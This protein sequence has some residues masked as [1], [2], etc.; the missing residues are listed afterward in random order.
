MASGLLFWFNL[1]LTCLILNDPVTS[2]L[3]LTF[4]LSP[5]FPPLSHSYSF[6][7]GPAYHCGWS[8]LIPPSPSFISFI[9]LIH[10]IF[11]RSFTQFSDFHNFLTSVLPP[12]QARLV[13]VAGPAFYPPTPFYKNLFHFTGP[14]RSL[15]ILTL[16]LYLEDP[17]YHRDRSQYLFPTPFAQIYSL[18]QILIDLYNSL[19]DPH[20]SSQFLS[21][22]YYPIILPIGPACHCGKSRL[23]HSF[24]S[25]YISLLP[26]T[27]PH[28][29]SQIPT[30]LFYPFC[31]L[32]YP[33]DP[34]RVSQILTNLY[35]SLYPTSKIL[36]YPYRFQPYYPTLKTR[37]VIE[38]A[39]TSYFLPT[40]FTQ[41]YFP[42]QILTDLY[43]SLT[44][45]H[46]PSQFLSLIYYP[47]I[48]PIGP[49]CHCGRSSLLHSFNF[50]YISF[51]PFTESHRPS[52]IP[53]YFYDSLTDPHRP[54][55]S[56]S[57]TYYPIT[58]L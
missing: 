10:D 21:L 52:Q 41:V 42:S 56:L 6:S 38:A 31:Q 8:R 4:S 50:I 47:I 27:D 32:F 12:I 29:S 57:L 48:L 58:Y 13:I 20:R 30:L 28:R 53:T 17:F 5:I 25:I 18:S 24:N 34:H 3:D 43:D 19:I 26:F 54:S 37:L 51:L 44:D 11:T 39:P 1:S 16:L 35:N 15:Q 9:S 33:T 2:C 45:P 46:R 14:H 55:H 36:T 49:A 23:L 40:P 22:I 7:L